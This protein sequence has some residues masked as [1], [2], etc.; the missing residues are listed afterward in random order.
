MRAKR[1]LLPA[2]LVLMTCAGYAQKKSERYWINRLKTTPVSQI[3]SALPRKAFDQ[4][5]R[6]LVKP[7]HPAY[8][9]NDC[10]E[11]NY[12]PDERGRSFPVCVTVTAHISPLK[13]VDL[14]FAVGTYTAP[15][16][17]GGDPHDKPGKVELMQ[18][19]ISPGDPRSM[20]PTLQVRKLRD[21][22]AMVHP[23]TSPSHP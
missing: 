6:T 23:Q 8:E 20:Q 22:E 13:R 14:T 15:Q 18:G 3:D 17:Q 1:H 9:V 19:M 4:W 10:G 11:R 16:K 7:A 2:I 5:F 12:S 21:L